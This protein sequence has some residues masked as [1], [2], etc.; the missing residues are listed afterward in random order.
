MEAPKNKSELETILGMITYLSRFAPNLA[1]LTS[2][3]RCLLTKGTEFIW[4]SAQDQAFNKVKEVIRTS[5]VLVY[6]DPSKPT[7]LQ[8]DASQKGLGATLMQEGRPIA[9]AS[10]SLTQSEQK[11][12]QIE[13][14]NVWNPFW[15]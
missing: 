8:V 6:F 12:A 2:P 7:T 10:K 4:D 13:K 9:F 5:P 14:K 3:M 1:E 11:Y 15:M